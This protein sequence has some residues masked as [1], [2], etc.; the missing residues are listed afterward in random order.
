[1]AKRKRTHNI[2]KMIKEGYGTGIGSEYKPWCI[3]VIN[4]FNV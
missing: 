4:S 3:Y 1:M 2:E